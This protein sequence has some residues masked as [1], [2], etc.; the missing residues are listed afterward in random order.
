MLKFKVN[1]NVKITSGKDKGRDGKIE[2]F[3]SKKMEVFIPGLNVYKK[4]IK[5]QVAKDGK[6]GIFELSRPIPV[7][8][9]A[10]VCPKCKK[11]TRVGFRVMENEK[12]RVCENVERR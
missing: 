7:S 3:D 8:K 5:A 9:I 12:V 4:H 2:A 10:L 6:G 1:D 11:T